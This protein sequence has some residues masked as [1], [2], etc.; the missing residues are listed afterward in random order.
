MQFDRQNLRRHR[1][2]QRVYRKWVHRS[3]R[4]LLRRHTAS[5]HVQSVSPMASRSVLQHPG[6]SARQAR[7]AWSRRPCGA[8][9]TDG[10]VEL[11]ASDRHAK[12]GFVR[13]D[14]PQVTLQGVER[15]SATGPEPYRLVRRTL[16][17]VIAAVFL[18]PSWT[19]QQIGTSRSPIL[20]RS[21]LVTHGQR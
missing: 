11:Q 1:R 17:V 5:A 15:P 19:R 8:V 16:D 18:G 12:G 7:V 6:R 20:E 9:L 3:V 13:T 21:A 2:S 4:P 10:R 14:E